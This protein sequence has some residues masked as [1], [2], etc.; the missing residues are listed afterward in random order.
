[1]ARTIIEIQTSILNEKNKY[2]VLAGLNSPSS[3][4]IWRLWVYVIAVCIH[5]FEKIMDIFKAEIEDKNSKAIVGRASWYAAK[6][7]EFQY[8]DSLTVVDGVLK[9]ATIDESKKIVKRAACKAGVNATLKVA[10]TDSGGNIV[11][12]DTA[13][14]AAF[15]DYVSNFMFAGTNLTVQS[16]N[17]D[18]LKVVVDVY[19][20]PLLFSDVV[21]NKVIIAINSYLANLDFNGGVKLSALQDAI[22]AVEGVT[23]V[24]FVDVQAKTNTGSYATVTRFYQTVSGYIQIDNDNFPLS[25]T[26]TMIADES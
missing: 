1:M 9:Y 5:E 25:T 8:G 13:Q 17:T 24:D 2:A 18:Y 26:I 14:L 6:A 23:D 4:A 3:V 12:L 15:N 20:D 22:Q 19:Y 11:G 16:Q 21:K 10:T 7:L